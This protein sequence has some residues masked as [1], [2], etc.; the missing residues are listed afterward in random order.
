MEYVI[1]WVTV[2]PGMR[3]EFLEASQPL[4]E[5]SRLEEGVEFFEFHLSPEDPNVVA[6]VECYRDAKVHE[7][8]V[9]SPHFQEFLKLI[10]RYLVRGRFENVVAGSVRVDTLGD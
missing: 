1:G 8:H 6:V 2:K 10:E 3:E 7:R 5:A 9:Q 4:I